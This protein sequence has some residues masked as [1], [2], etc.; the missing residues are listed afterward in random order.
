[1]SIVRRNVVANAAGS[2]WALLVS[3]A[4]VPFYIRFL[5]IEAYGVIGVFL[6]LTAIFSLLDLGLRA[7]LNRRLAQLSVQSDTA[8]EMRDL[9]RTLE[10]IYWGIGIAIGLSVALM[11]PMVATYWIKP[12]QISI[13]T[14]SRALTMIGFV[15][16]CQ[17]P[18]ALYS[19]G[20]MGLQ[21]Q[22]ALNVTASVFAT[23][24]SLGAVLLLW[25]LAPTLEVFFAWFIVVS[26]A[27]TLLTGYLLWSRLPATRARPAY[28]K[29][30]LSGI[31]RF[32]AGMTGISVLS[33]ILT[34]LD[35]VI[36][37]AVLSLE[38][39]GYYMLAWR[40][41]GA[42]YSLSSPINSAFFPRISQLAIETDKRELARLY[43]RGCQLTSVLVLPAAIVLTL[44]G[45]DVLYLWT[46]DTA[47]A[48]NSGPVLG[49]L[50]LG[51][52]V[53]T[54]MGLPVTLQI[55]HGWTRL[56]LVVGSTAVV[57]L[58][59]MIYFMSL[60]FGGIGAA[61]VWVALN[62]GYM[63]FMLRIMHRK[64][65]PG[66]LREW[67]LVDTGTP[68]FAALFVAIIWKLGLGATYLTYSYGVALLNLA[69]VSLATAAAALIAAPQAR[70]LL[71]HWILMRSGKI[72][73]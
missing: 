17:W 46:A 15:I 1:M 65:L 18:L 57:L 73:I 54:L 67:F 64:L 43:H 40:V 29:R 25:Q 44:F 52:A 61:S 59:P 11:A 28:S 63:L 33:I 45:K 56:V 53:N 39:F 20:M 32:A 4:A 50:A 72:G 41:A 51:T 2:G 70:S 16:A 48:V 55:A 37:S 36:L 35:K 21:K 30:Q 8:R 10:T 58:A 24:R 66:E 68:F 31:W 19:G 3:L 23:V 7:T 42:I 22:V 60:H 34:Q 14:A 26:L 12:Q 71:L 49:L 5:G 69:G 6:S 27:E 62:C 38:D 9:L 13:D 47:I